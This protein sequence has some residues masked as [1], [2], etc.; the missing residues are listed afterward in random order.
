VQLDL[1]TLLAQWA[2]GGLFFCWVTTRRREVGIGYG[3][4]LRISFGVMAVLSVISGAG[5]AS[6]P[7][8][9]AW[10]SSSRTCAER[11][12]CAVNASC[13]RR[14]HNASRR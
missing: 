3:W 9:Q 7:S 5:D 4:L 8:R 14:A 13:T 10:P 12:A 6:W 2:T 1:A 11:P